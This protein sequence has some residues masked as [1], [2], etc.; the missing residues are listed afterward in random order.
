MSSNPSFWRYNPR[1]YREK[2]PNTFAKYLYWVFGY[3]VLAMAL[4]GFYIWW[5]VIPM[6]KLT[7]ER[8]NREIERGRRER[9]GLPAETTFSPESTRNGTN[10]FSTQ[11]TVPPDPVRAAADTSKEIR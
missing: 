6:A 9:L 4:I 1:F 8:R 10:G 2:R 11:L 5:A 3:E 7:L